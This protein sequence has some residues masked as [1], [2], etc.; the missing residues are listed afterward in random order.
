MMLWAL[1]AL[2]GIGAALGLVLTHR[3]DA[4]PLAA[5]APSLNG[6]DATWAAGQ[7]PAP[8]FSLTDQSGTRFSLSAYRG[9]PVIVTFIDPLCRDFCPLEARVLNDA[10]AK[11]PAGSRPAI[12]AVS[13]NVYGNA[14]A[15]LLQD[16]RKW[17]AGPEW[18][19]AVGDGAELAPVWKSYHV[20]VL[21]QTK[22]LAGVT[23][24]QVLHTEAAYVVDGS[25]NERALFVWPFK[26]SAVEQTLRSLS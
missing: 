4:K 22:H 3:G 9:R 11:L 19:W 1:V 20:S 23:V 16:I 12:L 6:P 24:H 17:G 10:L 5:V 2:T 18:R 15:H 7:A 13:T 21:V 26:A 25:G 14:R 8:A